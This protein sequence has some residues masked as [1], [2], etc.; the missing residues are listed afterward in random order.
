MESDMQPAAADAS[1][2]LS[3]L[4]LSPL[5]ADGFNPLLWL[6]VS[7]AI[8]I[9][10]ARFVNQIYAGLANMLWFVWKRLLRRGKRAEGAAGGL[11]G[12][13]AGSEIPWGTR[14]TRAYL[15]LQPSK[16]AYWRR[17]LRSFFYYVGAIIVGFSY[18]LTHFHTP[19]D[20][21]LLYTPG[22][23]IAFCFAATHFL[24]CCVEDYPCRE[25]MG[26][27]PRERLV[28]FWGYVFHHFMTSAA[29]LSAVYSHQLASMCLMG[30]TFEGP[31]LFGCLREVISLFDEEFNLFV[32]VPKKLQQLNWFLAFGSLIPCRYVSIGFFIYST[33]YWQPYLSLLT[34]LM[35]ASY[36]TFG[37][38]F[39]LI[40]CYFTWLLTFWFR[41]D[42]RYLKKKEQK[43]RE[44][45]ALL[46]QERRQASSQPQGGGS[47][48]S[49][50]SSEDG[51]VLQSNG[52]SL[53]GSSNGVPLSR[54]LAASSVSAAPSVHNAPFPSHIAM[55]PVRAF[56]PSAFA[57]QNSQQWPSEFQSNAQG[58]VTYG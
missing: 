20:M 9:V 30:L 14:M 52:S 7:L 25:H 41:Q 49:Y 1:V 46:E 21:V 38:L 10:T 35:I 4:S 12:S 56:G 23:E 15:T 34:P 51:P 11:L 29:Y 27:T 22:M 28:V 39:M 36:Y 45:V 47:I 57:Q 31:V 54:P 8:W 19:T 55:A 17:L 53:H 40:N 33:V 24:W 48:Y 16:R 43:A 6:T 50:V 44:R 2:L 37:T 32:R 3:E 42:R 5:P 13:G 18:L 58:I 26:R